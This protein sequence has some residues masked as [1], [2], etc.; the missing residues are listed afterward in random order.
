MQRA[1]TQDKVQREIKA[2]DARK[3]ALVGLVSPATS[4]IKEVVPANLFSWP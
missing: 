4:G 1:G 3:E 2:R